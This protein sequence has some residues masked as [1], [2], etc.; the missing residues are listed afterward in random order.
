MRTGSK[1]YRDG[2]RDEAETT[3]RIMV[4]DQQDRPVNSCSLETQAILK[5]AS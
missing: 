5:V 1:S 2:K 4:K 3:T